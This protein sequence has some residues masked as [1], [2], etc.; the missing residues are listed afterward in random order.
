M[1][2]LYYFITFLARILDLA[3]LA[4]I[5]LSWIPINRSNA[6]VILIYEITEPI[7]APIRRLI[8]PLGGLDL[9]PMIAIILIQVAERVLLALLGRMV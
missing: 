6:V 2:I 1:S 3:I 9:S 8:P 7:L 5:V 4:R